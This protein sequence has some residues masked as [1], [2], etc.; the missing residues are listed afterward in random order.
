[1]SYKEKRKALYP[2][3]E[4]Q[5]DALYKFMLE[6]PSLQRIQVEGEEDIDNDFFKTIAIIKNMHPKPGA[7]DIS[8]EPLLSDDIVQQNQTKD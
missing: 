4:E 2:P 8:T 7:E 6:Y 5:L 1:M 3:V